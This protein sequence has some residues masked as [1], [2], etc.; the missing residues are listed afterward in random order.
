MH[1]TSKAS[2]K[3]THRPLAERVLGFAFGRNGNAFG[4]IN[5]QQSAEGR[6]G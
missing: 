1:A 4:L 5:E 3:P 6:L 2:P